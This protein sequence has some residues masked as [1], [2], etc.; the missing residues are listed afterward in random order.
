MLSWAMRRKLLYLFIIFMIFG[1]PLSYYVYKKMQHPPSCSDGIMNQNET[2]VDCGG[3]CRI[4]CFNNVKA[5]PD[6][7]WSRAYYVAHGI[8]NLVA[9]IQNPNVDYVSQPV[10]YKFS[11]YDENN[12]LITTRE[13]VTAIPTSK[14]F[15]IFEPTISTGELTPK[16]VKFDFVE[17]ITWIEYFGNKPELEVVEQRLSRTDTV[18]KIDAKILNKTLNTF[19]NVEVVAI[20]YDENGNAVLS[21]RTYIDSIA[22]RQTANVVFTWP[23]PITFTPSKVEIIPNL[24]LNQYK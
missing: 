4:A 12:V 18:P 19:K 16:I 23:E 13:G 5:S 10:K 14:I 1:T 9:Y 8:Y 17:P 6:I 11:V 20:I 22:D 7:Q 2:G 21:S 24:T 3:I 15:P